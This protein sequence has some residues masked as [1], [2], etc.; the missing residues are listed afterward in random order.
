MTA[1]PSRY[2]SLDRGELAVLVPELLLLIVAIQST[3]GAVA[4]K[5]AGW[6]A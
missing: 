4:A 1:M 3:A 5:P 6:A 2:A